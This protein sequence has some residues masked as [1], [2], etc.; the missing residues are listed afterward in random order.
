M[1]K[2]TDYDIVQLGGLQR[3]LAN[4][5][6]RLELFKNDKFLSSLR[7]VFDAELKDGARVLSLDVFDTFLI[8]DNS[9]ELLRFY[10]I[11]ETICEL[12]QVDLAGR[13]LKPVDAFIARQMGTR[14]TY[15]AS[16][17]VMGAR[18]GSLSDIYLTASRLLNLND[19]WAE[20][21]VEREISY[22]ATRITVN[23]FLLDYISAFRKQGGSAILVSD[24][25]F[26]AE[27]I[28][29][30]LRK[31]GVD[32]TLFGKIYSSGDE[33]ISKA[34]GLIF[35]KIE[36]DM[37]H[38]QFFHVGDSFKSDYVNPL[39]AGWNALHLPVSASDIVARQLSHDDTFTRIKSSHGVTAD[40]VRP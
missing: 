13:V 6:N 15:R 27:H 26:H 22:E 36:K 9:S 18:E 16:R 34:S 32:S 20:R 40:V 3:E 11:G 10:E 12:C 2:P 17:K 14:A 5:S 30:L 23:P 38:D 29:V 19:S 1:V 37:G 35:Q 21:L 28:E 8:R 31:L 7:A 24:M 4:C 33:K 25:Y 39:H